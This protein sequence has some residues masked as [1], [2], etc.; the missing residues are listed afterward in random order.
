MG[1]VLLIFLSQ[2]WQPE[3]R[4]LCHHFVCEENVGALHI[5]MDDWRGAL[6]M[7]VLESCTIQE[8]LFR[9]LMSL[10][11][12]QDQCVFFILLPKRKRKK[13]QCV[14]MPRRE[15]LMPWSH[16]CR[17]KDLAFVWNYI[18][19]SACSQ[20]SHECREDFGEIISEITFCNLKGDTCS[21]SPSQRIL[22][23]TIP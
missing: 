21:L 4:H 20:S 17:M 18:W 8:M 23:C 22:C 11:G 16:P 2:F 6:V 1:S 3:I 10:A 5:P 7:Q 19:Q 9:G 13:D 15:P 12:I 14:L